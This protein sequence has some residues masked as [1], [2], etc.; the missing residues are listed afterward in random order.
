MEMS[1]PRRINSIPTAAAAVDIIRGRGA[2]IRRK[3]AGRLF[4]IIKF[5]DISNS[6]F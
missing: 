1:T 4:F 6:R 5:A 2:G 3:T